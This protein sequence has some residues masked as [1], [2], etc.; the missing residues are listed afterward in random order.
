MICHS[1]PLQAT[2][3]GGPR[4]KAAVLDSSA[5]FLVAVGLVGCTASAEEVRPPEDQ[6]FF[7]T[8]ASVSPDDARL[9]G[10]EGLGLDSVDAL[11]L[12]VSLEKNFGL[13]IADTGQ[14]KDI[15]Q[16]VDSIATA[17]T[18]LENAKT[19]PPTG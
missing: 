5:R 7:P 12:V 4:S 19:R 3:L 9:F 15:L 18:R 14:A 11:Q 6:F 1:S 8:G 13:K 2:L 17:L 16:S 10:P